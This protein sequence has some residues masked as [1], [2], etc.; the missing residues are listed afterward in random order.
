VK[1]LRSADVLVKGLPKRQG[2]E[3]ASLRTDDV[4]APASPILGFMIGFPTQLVDSLPS[5]CFGAFKIGDL[6]PG[7]IRYD[8]STIHKVEEAAH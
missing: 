4:E 5:L 6:D 1:L 7:V 2:G 3:K 8:L